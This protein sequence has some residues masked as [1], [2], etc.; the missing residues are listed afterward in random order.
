MNTYFFVRVRLRRDQGRRSFIY[1][2][3]ADISHAEA[4]IDSIPGILVEQGIQAS[5]YNL[6][7]EEKC[8]Q[9]GNA[10]W[11]KV[12]TRTR[13]VVSDQMLLAESELVTIRVQNESNNEP[14][15]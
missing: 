15:S 2:P 7:I 3:Y 1:G 12:N 11:T 5:T 9:R 8:P 4:I 14:P 10:S 13:L 6:Y